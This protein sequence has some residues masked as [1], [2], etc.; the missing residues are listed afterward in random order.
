M[1]VCLLLA[2]T[3][4][5]GMATLCLS[6]DMPFGTAV[7]TLRGH[8]TRGTEYILYTLRAPR[9]LCAAAVG[10]ALGTSGAVFQTLLRNPLAGPDLMGLTTG[11]SFGAVAAITLCQAAL[12]GIALGA[13]LGGLA[14]AAAVYGLSFRRGVSGHRIIVVGIAVNAIATTGVNYLL[15]RASVQQAQPAQLWLIGNLNGAGWTQCAFTAAALA[16]LLPAACLLRRALGALELGDDKARSLGTRVESTRLAALALGVG[17]AA[18]ATA[19]A[20]PVAFVALSAPQLARRLARTGTP[21][22]L[23]A[24]AMGAFLVVTSDWAAQWALSTPLPV[25][26]VTAALGGGY[27][28]WTLLVAKTR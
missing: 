11:S 22:L 5:A 28:G 21:P 10:T 19:V 4:V 16:I 1:V 3:G 17:L 23:S 8:G 9:L 7:Q 20:G 26:I 12:P 27:L 24:G 6:R 18:S 2:A 14:A 13:V 15:T 25:G